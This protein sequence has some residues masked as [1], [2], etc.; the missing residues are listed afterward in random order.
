MIRPHRGHPLW[1]AFLLGSVFESLLA[2][3]D[4]R[5]GFRQ[6]VTA[7]IFIFI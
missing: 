7:I 4:I 3:E 1:L 5:G 2:C 6:F